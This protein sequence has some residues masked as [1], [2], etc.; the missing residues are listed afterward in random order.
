MFTHFVNDGMGFGDD[1]RSWR[2][3]RRTEVGNLLI[4][5]HSFRFTIS[6]SIWCLSVIELIR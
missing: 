1:W 6:R 2:G 3:D 5:N 4:C